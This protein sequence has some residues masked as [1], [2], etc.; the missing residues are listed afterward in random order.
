MAENDMD[1][2]EACAQRELASLKHKYTV[3]NDVI[4]TL[5]RRY[6]RLLDEKRA[7]DFELAQLK[8]DAQI[9]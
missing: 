5:T 4:Q 6:K 1:H 8:F 9:I 7:V 2:E 3:A